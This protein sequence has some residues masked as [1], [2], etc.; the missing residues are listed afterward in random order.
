MVS[1][2]RLIFLRSVWIPS[3]IGLPDYLGYIP[4]IAFMCGLNSFIC[5]T[6]NTLRK[7][8]VTEAY[9][10]TQGKLCL[11]TQ[12]GYPNQM[13]QPHIWLQETENQT[14]EAWANG[15][16]LASSKKKSKGGGATDLGPVDQWNLMFPESIG[17]FSHS[18]M[19]VAADPAISSAFKASR[20][21]K[22]NVFHELCLF[23]FSGR[24]KANTES[25][26]FPELTWF[27]SGST[28]S[29]VET[30]GSKCVGF[31]PL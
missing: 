20:S 7:L 27:T 30:W 11:L 21:R 10:T 28:H 13:S 14:M 3:L 16:L 12:L 8:L 31:W 4:Y 6:P 17:F 24:L 19:E 18:C 9:A 25:L 5:F 22:K 2:K 1:R 15:N 23:L 26:P 29:Y